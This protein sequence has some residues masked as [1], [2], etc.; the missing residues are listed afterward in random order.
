MY[1]SITCARRALPSCRGV[2]LADAA[3]PDEH[4]R[5]PP[6]AASK[7]PKYTCLRHAIQDGG[8][9]CQTAPG[10]AVDTV[11]TQ[12]LLDTLTPLAVEVALT[13]QTELQTRAAKADPLRRHH[14]DLARHHADLAHR[15][16]LHR[17]AGLGRGTGREADISLRLVGAALACPLATALAAAELTELFEIL[18]R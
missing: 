10:S 12:L 17:C 14:V 6:A 4:A 1:A 3:E 2:G 5:P 16:Y 15:R 8:R 18:A 13:V 11:I 7:S 9:G